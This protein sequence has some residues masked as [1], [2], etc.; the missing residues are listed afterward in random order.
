[1]S[2]RARLSLFVVLAFLPVGVVLLHARQELG[3]LARTT[4]A[5]ET[6]QVAHAAALSHGRALAETRVAIEV[7]SRL[8][9]VRSDPAVACEDFIPSVMVDRPYYTVVGVIAAS[10]EMVCTVP[11][12]EFE[13][14]FSDRGYFQEAFRTGQFAMGS[15][16][17]ARITG[18]PSVTLAQPVPGA[19]GEVAFL[20]AAGIDLE[21]LTNHAGIELE[22]RDA[23]VTVFDREG[24]ILV[25]FPEGATLIG[26][27]LPAE[28]GE[29]ARAATG[30]RVL[31]SF[32]DID[33]QERIFAMAPLADPD[34]EGTPGAW[35]T[36]G[37]DPSDAILGADRV[38][39]DTLLGLL[40]MTLLAAAGI[41]LMLE[42]FLLR[43]LSRI[44]GT[45]E[46]FGRG[47]WD[48]RVGDTPPDDE[49]ASLARAFD[50]MAARVVELRSR[51][52][53]RAREEIHDREERFRQ[54]AE[55]IESVFW[56]V[57]PDTTR[58]L[59]VSPAVERI[60]GRPASDFMEDDRAWTNSIHP[61]DRD[62]AVARLERGG[63]QPSEAIY[64]II[65]PDGGVRWIRDRIFPV[66]DETGKVARIAGMAEDITEAR[67]LED[68]LRQAQ[69][70]EAVGRLAG[71]IAH[72]FNNIITAIMGHTQLLL[73]DMEPDSPLRFEVEEVLQAARRAANLTGQLLAFSRKQ[74]IQPR[75]VNVNEVVTG[76]QTM[77]KRAAGDRTGMTFDLAQDPPDVIVDPGQLEQ[78]LLNLVVNSRDALPQGG[79]IEIRTDVVDVDATFVAP[80]PGEMLPGRYVRI[81]VTDDGEGI[82]PE[83]LDHIFEP[84][85]TTK[86]VG[87]GT[88]LGLATVYGIVKQAGGFVWAT[89][90]PG[91]GSTFDLYF[92]PAPSGMPGGGDGE[93][94]EVGEAGEAGNAL[95]GGESAAVSDPGRLVLLVEDDVRIRR[96]AHR[97]LEG[98]GFQVLP[99]A[100]ALEARALMEAGVFTEAGPAV[101]LADADLPGGAGPELATLLRKHFPGLPAI[102]ITGSAVADPKGSL[103]GASGAAT[104]GATD[105]AGATL[106]LRLPFSDGE[107]V[108][109]VRRSLPE[110]SL[111]PA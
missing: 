53:R 45:A 105:S 100:S 50:G 57:D 101:L 15:Y 85:F 21:A 65:R 38:L 30:E 14:N 90:K 68:Q 89:S 2:L 18:R 91:A 58:S 36:V 4:V 79:D 7:L 62:A 97:I 66:E 110:G 59:Y 27:V 31:G 24:T 29:A 43:R 11:A 1:M 42:F 106:F 99:T 39:R 92:P 95:H 17:V 94:G 33:G 78:V 75:R 109:A 47:D 108:E 23:T 26:E 61:D 64:R 104:E 6:L 22:G 67:H 102:L 49:V 81:R 60:W 86:G 35:V 46:A 28:L 44:S 54:M 51:E 12:L 88:G 16:Q 13:G 71:G 48:A 41:W 32:R 80:R 55:N 87:E 76:I 8:P 9:G 3:D 111:P 70:I 40:F 82:P 74:V 10:G 56:L 77:L 25:R 72:D 84:F 5:R 103:K 73:E 83:I 93:D 107:L 34:P 37:F 20:L 52:S 69:R 98:A 19:D 63:E 96:N